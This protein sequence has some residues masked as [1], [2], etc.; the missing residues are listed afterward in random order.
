MKS[1]ESK[2]VSLGKQDSVKY[3]YEKNITILTYNV[4]FGPF[5]DIE[6]VPEIE[7]SFL[8]IAD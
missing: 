2:V 6:S 8:E 7:V 5:A 4:N 1:F 3:P